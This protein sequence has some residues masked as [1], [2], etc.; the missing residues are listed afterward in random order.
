MLRLAISGCLTLI[1]PFAFGATSFAAS[2]G[3]GDWPEWRGP[4]SNGVAEAD[5]APPVEWS[6]TKNVIWKT[7][8]PGRGHS[9]PTVVGER[10]F[11][12]TADE[13]NQKQGVLAFDRKTG[14]QV[15]I[16]EISSGGFPKQHKKNTQA[17]ATIA[18]DG[19]RLF[20]TFHHHNKITLAALSLDG[21]VEWKK[22]IGPFHP[23]LYEYGYAP[24]PI[25][26]G[27]TVIVAADY[28]KGGWIAAFDGK[29]GDEVWRTKRP[30]ML[31]FSS[32]VVAD[33]AGR[34][35]LLISGCSLVA[36]YDPQTG[37]PLWDVEATTMATCGTIVWDGDLIFAS[38]GYP[39]PETVC[40]RAD[41]SKEVLWTNS[42]KCYEQS[43]MA[44]DG[45]V[46]C[47]TDKGVAYC[48]RGSDGEEMWK[49][50]LSGPVSAS[51]VLVGDTI[52]QSNEGGT[53]FVFKANPERF[54]EVAVNRLGDESFASPAI[55]GGRI[56]LRVADNSGNNRQEYLYCIGK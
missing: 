46:Y 49:E 9:S 23:Q 40:I 22:E 44:V 24:S 34:E 42:Q 1:L 55:C 3:P 18:C 10:I 52:Y 54:E 38:G 11:L 47:L 53:T 4:N 16:T 50:R 30:F 14:E 20:V 7:K 12:A 5:Q 8:V 29:S 41:G 17:T 37:K 6:S 25:L 15:W 26:Y 56:Y 21:N 36:S 51:P 33:V 35:Q 43:M 19:E 48:W 27:T 31:S 13:A 45:Y 32:P 28:E 2:P 39:K